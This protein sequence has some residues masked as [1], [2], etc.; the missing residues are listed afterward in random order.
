[1]C[2]HPDENDEVIMLRDKT[3]SSFGRSTSPASLSLLEANASKSM[4]VAEWNAEM[5][6]YNCYS[7]TTDEDD[8]FT[9]GFRPQDEITTEL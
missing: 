9:L 2:R 8:F 5:P 3:V 7:T 6:P 1:M 4:L